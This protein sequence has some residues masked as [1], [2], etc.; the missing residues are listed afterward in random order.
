MSQTHYEILRNAFEHRRFKSKDFARLNLTILGYGQFRSVIVVRG[1][2][3]G[4]YAVACYRDRD[5]FAS[6][7]IHY[8]TVYPDNSYTME[9]PEYIPLRQKYLFTWLTQ[10][11]YTVYR[12]RSNKFDTPHRVS[13]RLIY[14]NGHESFHGPHYAVVTPTGELHRGSYTDMSKLADSFAFPIKN[15]FADAGQ[16]PKTRDPVQVR[17]WIPEK[18]KVYRAHRRK[19]LLHAIA[20]AKLGAYDEVIK[21]LEAG[22]NP[23][24]NAL[25]DK[26]VSTR[27][28]TLKAFTQLD[29]DSKETANALAES[30]LVRWWRWP[31]K[32]RLDHEKNIRAT[33][34]LKM[35][36]LRKKM[37]AVVYL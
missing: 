6:D 25:R 37:G 16:Q 2:L 23:T 36:D 35:E 26:L 11:H 15:I 3:P 8:A 30:S 5:T 32:N 29:P 34:N 21:E 31:V 27:V 10:G 20:R 18:R 33:V 12:T 28:Q 4:T 1:P 9:V 13:V 14:Q 22:W 24:A 17:T 7:R 19:L